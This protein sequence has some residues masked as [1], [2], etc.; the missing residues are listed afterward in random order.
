M[1]RTITVKGIGK[2]TAVPDCVIIYISID[3]HAQKYDDTLEIAS[4]KIENLNDSLEK[5]GFGKK[6]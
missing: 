1:S 4:Q 6:P 5:I 3:T 2:V